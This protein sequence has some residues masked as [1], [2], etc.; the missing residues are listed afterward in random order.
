RPC[1]NVIRFA[2]L[3]IANSN[4]GGQGPRRALLRAVRGGGGW[5]G[6]YV[7]RLP[8]VPLMRRSPFA[9]NDEL[10][11]RADCKGAPFGSV[12]HT[13]RPLTPIKQSS[14]N[15]PQVVEAARRHSMT[16]IGVGVGD[17]FPL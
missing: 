17:D 11:R 10:S 7:S 6:R 13:T 2:F 8:F 5:G 1:R 15:H 14:N 4:N 9:F 16:K 12:L 3:P